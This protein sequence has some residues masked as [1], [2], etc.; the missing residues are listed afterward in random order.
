MSEVFYFRPERLEQ[1]VHDLC[2]A[3]GSPEGE[4]RLLAERLVKS[5]LAGHPSHGVIRMPMYTRMV[6]SG[7]IR[8]GAE[9]SIALDRGSTAV[10]DGHRAYGQVAAEYAMEV[11][12]GRGR[13]HGVAAVGVRNLGHIGRLADYAVSAAAAGCIGM[14]FASGGGG[15]ILVAPFG[16]RTRRMSTNPMAVAFPSEREYPVVFD[17]ATSVWAEGKFRVLRASGQ[18]APEDTVIDKEGRPTT[19]AADFYGGGAILPLG[20]KNGYKGYLLNFMVEVLAGLL[21]GG[22]YLGRDET[23]AFANCTLMVVLDVARFRA[24]PEFKQEIE[25]LI[26]YLKDSPVQEGSEVLWPGEVEARNEAERMRTGIPLA[27]KTVGAIQEE[28][29]HYEVP[30]RLEDLGQSGPFSG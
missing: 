12:I 10:V 27:A 21:T 25:A 4:A 24:L 3:S 23:P 22:G 26:R 11:A 19:N 5:D 7:S 18:P 2:R 8:P 9:P 13:T 14:V 30:T 1:A 29:D 17:M 16:G 15:G 6:R 28:L 20:G